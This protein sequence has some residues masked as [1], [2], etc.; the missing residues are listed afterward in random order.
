[1]KESPLLDKIDETMRHHINEKEKVSD[2]ITLA[3]QW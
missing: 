3:K 2:Y 1:M